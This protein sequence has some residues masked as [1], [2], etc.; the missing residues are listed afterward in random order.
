MKSISEYILESRMSDEIKIKDSKTHKPVDVGYYCNDKDSLTDT[1]KKYD[2]T[3]K[4]WIDKGFFIASK[5]ISFEFCN[6]I[7]TPFIFLKLL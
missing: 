2:A 3:G 4:Y 5:K 7:M 6:P 1:I